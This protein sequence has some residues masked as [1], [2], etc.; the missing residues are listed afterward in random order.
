M[1]SIG[2][3][4]EEAR[5]R[6]GISIREAAESTKIRGDYLHKFENNQ[7]D[8]RLPE[9]YVRNFLRSYASFL[10]LPPDKIIADYNALTHVDPKASPRT[11]NREVYGRMDISTTK[12]HHNESAAPAGS[13]GSAPPMSADAAGAAAATASS[14]TGPRNP[15]T[16]TPPA[17]SSGSPLDKKLLI[18]AGAAALITVILLVVIIVSV[19]KCSS[20]AP[21]PRTTDNTWVRPQPNDRTFDIVAKNGPVSVTLT[22]T[23]D[24]TVY[25]QGTIQPG[26]KRALPRRVEM[27]LEAAPYANVDLVFD[28]KSWQITGPTTIH[29]AQ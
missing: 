3:R 19:S 15:V 7:Y 4:L 14:A 29:A 5:K 25:Y 1:Q 26:D 8:I 6:K 2:E 13:T 9:I 27:R 17:H 11:V 22:S 18:K 21:A 24:G 20:G 28:G 10:K 12:E 16:F 23:A